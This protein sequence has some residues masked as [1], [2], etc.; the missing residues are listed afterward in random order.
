[1]PQGAK[2]LRRLATI[3]VGATAAHGVGL[4]LR[5]RFP[6]APRIKQAVNMERKKYGL[7]RDGLKD[8]FSRIEPGN[9]LTFSL[10]DVKVP[11]LR[12]KAGELNMQAGY[13]KYSVSVDS[14]TKKVRV[15]NN[16]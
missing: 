7:R 15:I 10:D 4:R 2:Q 14:V 6:L 5:V 13:R 1:M 11:S 12:T 16:G 8:I 9:I 3:K